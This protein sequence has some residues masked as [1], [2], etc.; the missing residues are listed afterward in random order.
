[1][2]ESE[3]AR[4]YGKGYANLTARNA[5]IAVDKRRQQSRRSD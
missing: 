5:S 4:E 3:K 2:I 1:M